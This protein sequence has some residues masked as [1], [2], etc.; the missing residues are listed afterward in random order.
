MGSWGSAPFQDD[1]AGDRSCQLTPDSD[2]RAIELALTS[3]E[4]GG[5]P[6][7][8]TSQTAIAAAEVI[9]AGPGHP[10]LSRHERPVGPRSDLRPSGQ[11]PSAFKR[12]HAWN[13]LRWGPGGSPG[14]SPGG[15]SPPRPHADDRGR[16]ADAGDRLTARAPR[17]PRSRRGCRP[18]TSQGA[19]RP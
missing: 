11:Q 19:P 16:H 2:E 3:V 4:A 14:V 6:D 12:I 15:R 17:T 9:A 5:D 18:T 10:V 8:S 13:C 1:D 7:L